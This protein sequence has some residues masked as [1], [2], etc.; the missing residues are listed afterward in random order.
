[1]RGGIFGGI[2]KFLMF[3]RPAAVI[4]AGVTLPLGIILLMICAFGVTAGITPIT[5]NVLVPSIVA[6]L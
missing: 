2:S 4:Y 6:T 1:M 5:W 3:V